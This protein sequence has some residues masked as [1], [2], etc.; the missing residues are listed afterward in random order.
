MGRK[1]KREEKRNVKRKQTNKWDEGREKDCS[2]WIIKVM[3][4][5]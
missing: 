2:K 3:I 4:V 5:A 1:E